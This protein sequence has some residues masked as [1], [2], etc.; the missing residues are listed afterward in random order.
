MHPPEPRFDSFLAAYLER[1]FGTL[2][3]KEMERLVYQYLVET[4]RIHD[5]DDHYAVSRQ[6]RVT[7]LKAANLAYEYKLL[8]TPTLSRDALR[9]QFRSSSGTDTSR[10]DSEA[11]CTGD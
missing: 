2:S 4:Q 1:G 9:K 3:K 6:L 8:S 5:S 7:P 10:P 11:C